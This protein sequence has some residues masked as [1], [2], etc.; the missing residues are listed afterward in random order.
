MKTTRL[1]CLFCFTIALC[2]R[3]AVATEPSA[4]QAY[5]FAAR[6]LKYVETSAKRPKLAARL[7]ALK[8]RL[9]KTPVSEI[10]KLRREIILSHP[11][12]A[13]DSLLI[14]KRP[15]SRVKNHMVDHYLGRFSL[16]GEGLVILKDWKTAPKQTFITKGRLPAGTITH[17]DLSFDARKA[18]FAFCD[19]RQ[20]DS[21]RRGFHLYEIALDSTG[22]RQLTGDSRDPMTG[23]LG[24]MTQI[25]ED[26]DP[27]Y[28][29]DGGIAFTS[30][31]TMAAV[32]CANYTR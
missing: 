31:R 11:A 26:F 3:G 21:R 5:D 13:F 30:T 27:C 8:S 18:V 10:L 2:S 4:K 22:L 7:T 24:R 6:T 32:R 28:L 29:P 23:R 17:P 12:L 25:I 9:D 19:H 1:L 14:N 15:V 16:P 20:K